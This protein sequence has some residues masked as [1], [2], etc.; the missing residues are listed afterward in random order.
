[1]LNTIKYEL[2]IHKTDNTHEVFQ[3]RLSQAAINDG[4]ELMER[5]DVKGY[6][7]VDLKTNICIAYDGKWWEN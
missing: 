5:R 3:Y 1:M 4:R 6:E 7:V 2:H